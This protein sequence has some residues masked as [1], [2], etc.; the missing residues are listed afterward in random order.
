MWDVV[1]HEKKWQSAEFKFGLPGVAF[2]Q[3]GRQLAVGN[4]ADNFVR[5]YNAADGEKLKEL[6]G[7]RAKVHGITYSPNGKMFATASLDRDAKLWDA[8][9]N[10][11]IK[12]FVGHK[13]FVFTVEF[14]PDG[15]TLL[16]ASTTALPGSGT[17]SPARRFG[18]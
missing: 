14:S 15:K 13:D 10:R 12:T 17:S 16:T 2:S 7:H 4:F 1:E 9:T 6:R 8:A 18:S 11:E 5:L 3:D